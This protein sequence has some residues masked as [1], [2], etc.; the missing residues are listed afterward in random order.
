MAKNAILP[1]EMEAFDSAG[2]TGIGTFDALNPDGLD[3]SV[4]LLRII[5]DSDTDVLLSYDGN[6]DHDFLPA[7]ETLQ[8]DFQPSTQI[9]SSIA[10]IRQGTVIY[11]EGVAGVGFIY[12]TGYYRSD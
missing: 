7:G 11:A 10:A 8:I 4:F 6:L 9:G 12:V 1:I 3:H 5:N 2:L